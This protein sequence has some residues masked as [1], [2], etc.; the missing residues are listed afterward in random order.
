MLTSL[1]RF[2]EALLDAL[3]PEALL[4]LSSDH[5]NIEDLATKS[6]TRHPVPLIARG[7]GAHAFAEA[8]SLTDVTPAILRVLTDA[9]A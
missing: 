5:G 1:D 4:V 2:F 9:D 8:G 3:P 6:H 7:P